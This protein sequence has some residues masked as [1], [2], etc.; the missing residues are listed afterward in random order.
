[1]SKMIIKGQALKNIP[2]QD[3]PVGE[4]FEAVQGTIKIGSQL[5]INSDDTPDEVRRMVRLMKDSGL[6]L[7]RLFM[8]WEQLEPQQG[9]WYFDNYDAC[10]HQA[11]ASDMLVIPT[12]MSVSPPGWMRL[13]DGPQSIADLDDPTYR[14]G[15]ESY[16]YQIVSRYK[17]HPAMHSYILW[18]EPSRIVPRS[19]YAMIAY[20]AY[21]EK[22]YGSIET[23]NELTYRKYGSFNDIVEL[24][25]REKSL[26][27]N[28]AVFRSFAEQLDW[29]RFSV[30]N[31]NEQLVWI[32][33]E[34]RKWDQ[35]HPTHVNPHNIQMDLQ[36][37]GQSIWEEAEI[38]DFI[39]CSAHPMWH[40]LRFPERRWGQ[41]VAYYADLM[42]SATRD[43]SGTFWITELQGGT[44]LYSALKS[45]TPS[46]AIIR[47]WIWEG[48]ACGAKAVVFWCF[49]SRNHGYEAAEWSLLDQ[50]EEPSPRL[51][52]IS[53]TVDFLAK[54]DAI[55]TELRPEPIQ[56][57]IL[58]SEQSWGLGTV[59]GEGSD[60]SNPRN[61]NMYG[62]ACAGAYL[63]FSDLSLSIGFVNEQ[64]LLAEGILQGVQ[65]F[66]L[67]NTI[68]LG[69]AEMTVLEKFVARGGLLIADGLTAMKDKNGKLSK[70]TLQRA[71]S[72]F[73]AE[74]KD[75]ETD[76]DG[77]E[78]VSD[79]LPAFQG[80]FYRLPLRVSVSAQVIGTFLDGRPAVT[81]QRVGAGKAVRMGTNLFQSYFAQPN[82]TIAAFIQQLIARQH[83]E[84]QTCSV[85]GLLQV[86][87]ALRLKR[88]DHPRG[89]MLIV[90]NRHK[91]AA[92]A[93][94]QLGCAGQLHMLETGENIAVVNAGELVSISIPAE[95]I[96]LYFYENN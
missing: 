1:M 35:L 9:N 53:E 64:R 74:I 73:G 46:H 47:Q 76:D 78:I 60:P 34:I 38:V 40:S 45:Y 49:N 11:A 22:I 41:S 80:W 96:G 50:L 67:P 62:D 91:S 31:L 54:Y 94:L 86:G 92:E 3:K 15:A 28:E 66:V 93:Q 33:N 43:P 20:A 65:I 61:T 26:S 12:L 57:M 16:I 39:G 19:Y 95:G 51:Q 24:S 5:F 52:A 14:Q 71:G 85:H 87:S 25:Q 89:T 10:F 70:V 37:A 90:L 2:G 18:N 48:I 6:S 83:I 4:S 88:L 30:H 75:I 59:E 55:F 68:V 29:Q 42:K 7:I 44:T 21:V 36:I 17:D 23:Y 79:S 13:T 8:I 32:R 58:Y 77:F 56:V 27:V 81:Q 72:L 82:P 63:L 84:Q 69:A